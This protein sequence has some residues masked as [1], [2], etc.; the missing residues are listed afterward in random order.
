MILDT[1]PTIALRSHALMHAMLALSSLH[2]ARLQNTSIMASL[3]HYH[4]AIRRLARDVGSP[5][6]R[7]HLA[8]VATTLL[9]GY[10][11]VTSGDHSKWCDHLLGS[12]Q[13][14]KQVDFA[15]MT[16]YIWQKRREILNTRQRNTIG[17]ETYDE[18]ADLPLELLTEE[19]VDENLIG[20]LMGKA[21]NYAQFGE[22]VEDLNWRRKSRTGFSQRELELYST[23]RDLYWWYLKQ[24]TL[25]SLLSQNKPLCVV[26]LYQIGAS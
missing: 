5:T 16:K 17:E 11:E 1:L 23:Q 18:P 4:L 8:T 14:L 25:Q 22:I 21:V 19:E 9:L 24:D 6:K 10:Y 26:R 2:I 20:A 15:G 12:N 3:R 13:L 7:K